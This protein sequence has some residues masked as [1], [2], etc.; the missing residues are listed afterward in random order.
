MIFLIQSYG[1]TRQR[2]REV[3]RIQ[4]ERKRKMRMDNIMCDMCGE[5]FTFP[6]VTIQILSSK[7]RSIKTHTTFDLCRE[8]S[9]GFRDAFSIGL[10]Y[11]AEHKEHL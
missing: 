7:H 11:R 6:Y 5:K 1:T 3:G 2:S 9:E 10:E 8:C 4:Y